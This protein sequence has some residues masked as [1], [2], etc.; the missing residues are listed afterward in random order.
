MSI[1]RVPRRDASGVV[2]YSAT[3]MANA[4]TCKC[5][6]YRALHS[7]TGCSHFEAFRQ[8]R[9]GEGRALHHL[10]Q[11]RCASE[12]PS[13]RLS[14]SDSS[15]RACRSHHSVTVMSRTDPLPLL[16]WHFTNERQHVCALGLVNQ[17]TYTS[18]VSAHSA[19]YAAP[20]VVEAGPVAFLLIAHRPA[21]SQ[22]SMPE[23]RG[24]I[25]RHSPSETISR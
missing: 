14:A 2:V 5:G 15:R 19:I 3:C 13:L 23:Q 22:I 1:T 8:T 16:A 17:D 12:Y 18:V 21:P 6:T 9:L 20:L 25:A 24:P 4:S 7:Q 11:R 10:R